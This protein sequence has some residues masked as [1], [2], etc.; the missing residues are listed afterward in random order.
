MSGGIG[1]IGVDIAVRDSARALDAAE[2]RGLM[3]DDSGFHLCGIK[4]SLV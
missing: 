1:I 4:F 2:E 3:V